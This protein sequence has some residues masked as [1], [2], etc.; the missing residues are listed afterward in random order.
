[1]EASAAYI[2]L[3]AD[4]QEHPAIFSIITCMLQCLKI[5][6]WILQMKILFNVVSYIRK[7]YYKIHG[8]YSRYAETHDSSVEFSKL[9]VMAGKARVNYIFK[10]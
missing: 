9:F 2:W 10:L 1:M 5:K 8:C 4:L 3:T 6:L 7:A